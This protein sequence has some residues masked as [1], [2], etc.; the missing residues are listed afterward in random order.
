MILVKKWFSASMP[1]LHNTLLFT[2]TCGWLGVLN[3]IS[4][5]MVHIMCLSL[6]QFACMI[7]FPLSSVVG[8]ISVLL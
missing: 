5:L 3:G 6:G 2:G 8:V 4:L 1:K 7:S